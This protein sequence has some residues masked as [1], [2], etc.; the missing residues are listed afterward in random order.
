MGLV[1]P[2]IAIWNKNKVAIGLTAIAWVVN[3]SF[4]VYG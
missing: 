4:L 1:L 3:V 2:S